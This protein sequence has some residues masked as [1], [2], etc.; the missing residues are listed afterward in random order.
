[1][2]KTFIECKKCYKNFKT[3]TK[4]KKQKKRNNSYTK[5]SYK[6]ETTDESGSLSYK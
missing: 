4:I 1:M 6:V 3:I 5:K 2:K